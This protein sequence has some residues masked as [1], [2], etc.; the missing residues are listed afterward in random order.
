MAAI[1]FIQQ[2]RACELRAVSVLVAI[3]AQRKFDFELRGRAGRDVALRAGDLRVGAFQRVSAGCMFLDGERRGL[4]AFHRVAAF[5]LAAIFSLQELA[6]VR[7]RL[8]AVCA[9][10]VR[11]RLLEVAALVT[12]GAVHAFV[13][14]AKRE[15]GLVVIE[16][17]AQACAR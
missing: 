8:V 9:Q 3:N 2:R 5:A 14:S 15:A 6:A 1:A 10:R 16:L 7:I 11:H 4:P 12:F 17:C 13:F